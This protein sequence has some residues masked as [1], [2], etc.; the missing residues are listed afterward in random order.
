MKAQCP[1]CDGALTLDSSVEKS[2]VVT[3]MDCKNKLEVISIDSGN[4]TA[5]LKEAPK[6]EEDWGE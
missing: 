2:E 3:C 6:V 5:S 4:Q 1:I